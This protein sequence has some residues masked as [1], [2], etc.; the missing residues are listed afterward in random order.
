MGGMSFE[1]L[2]SSSPD[3]RADI[4]WWLLDIN[5]SPNPIQMGEP[6]TT[7]NIDASL[8][9]WGAHGNQATRGRW[10]DQEADDRINALEPKA[11]LLG[12]HSLT[13]ISQKHVRVLSDNT[14]VM[15]QIRNMG[16]TRSKACNKIACLIWSWTKE[17]RIWLTVA[18]IPGSKYPGQPQKWEIT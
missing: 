12:L 15:T 2:M 16:G 17:H 11:I 9:G 13:R 7:V 3:G 14:T 18:H 1:R 6:N 5:H 4:T 8:E 10:L